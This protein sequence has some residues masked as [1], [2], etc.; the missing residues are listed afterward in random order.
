MAR[1]I[2]IG[3]LIVFGIAVAI[4][5]HLILG[6]VAVGVWIYLFTM[7]WKQKK[8][9]INDQMESRISELHL[10]RIKVFLMVAL[11]SFLVF[12]VS[13][14]VHNVFHGQSETEESVFFIISLVALFMFIVVTAGGMFI[15]L[16][17][18]HK[19]I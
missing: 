5:N 17:E 6:I 16:K 1:N 10:K 13:A 12:I 7:V 14:I 4:V 11:L 2:L 18:R 9:A 8:R 3:I 15:F 19:T